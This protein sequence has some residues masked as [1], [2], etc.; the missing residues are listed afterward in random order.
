MKDSAHCPVISLFHPSNWV[1]ISY[2]SDPTEVTLAS[3]LIAATQF[4]ETF[5]KIASNW[6]IGSITPSVDAGDS[7]TPSHKAIRK[8]FIR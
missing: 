7:M 4:Q 3:D 2:V 8:P 5:E 6:L 1:S